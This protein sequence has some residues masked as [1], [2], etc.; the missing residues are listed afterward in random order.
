MT[1]AGTILVADDKKEILE[2]LKN[3][4]KYDFNTVI[5]LNDPRQ[6][7]SAMGDHQVDLVLLDMNFSPGVT[8]GAEGLK[9][10]KA[11]LEIDPQ[12]VVIP[13]TAFGDINLAVKAMQAGGIDFIL[14]PWDPTKL[15]AT[16]MAAYQLRQSRK[17]VKSLQETRRIMDQD[18]SSRFDILVGTSPVMEQ[19]KEISYK[20]AS[21][22]ASIL[23]TGENGTGK[24][25]IARE[26]HRWSDRSACGFIS[27]DM[28]SLSE[29]L[30]ES[31]MFGHKKGAFTDAGSD[32]AGRFEIASGGTLFMDEIGNLSMHLQSKLLR[33]LEENTI[34]PVGSNVTIPVDARLI[35][36][37]NRNLK[38]MIHKNVFREDLFFRINTIEL[39]IPSLRERAED[40]PLL[41]DYFLRSF[42]KKYNKT[43]RRLSG[44]TMDALIRYRWPGNI[45]E[46]KHMS[47]KAV[48]LN[49]SGILEPEDFFPLA[50]ASDKSM[51]N[52]LTSLAD[53]EKAAIENAL[54]TVS[55]N[56]SRA[57]RLLDISRTTL[58]SKMD[59]HGI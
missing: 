48:I 10:L 14:K 44:K 33:V 53:I 39:R 20:A 12:A 18:L 6:I 16:I 3:M 47:E 34:T 56:I 58:Y 28:G 38:E 5:T 45:R 52:P 22:D 11:I 4:L 40:I 29:S 8:S 17:E 51:Q 36:A 32:R 57:A 26:I 19:L 25:L 31:E 2:S 21:S 7:P 24:E 30:F 27:V 37:T 35:T 23:I 9:W 55:G 1:R 13:M 59:K 15:M 41:L 54:K 50:H 43:K 46:L 49:D 42:E